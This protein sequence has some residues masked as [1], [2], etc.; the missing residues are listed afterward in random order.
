MTKVTRSL[1][2]TG[3]ESRGAAL[4]LDSQG[5]PTGNAFALKQYIDDLG[6]QN[7]TIVLLGFSYGGIIIREFLNLNPTY[8]EHAKAVVTIDT[9]HNG[10]PGGHPAQHCERGT[11]FIPFRM[12]FGGN[13]VSGRSCPALAKP[14]LSPRES[15]AIARYPK[16][17]WCEIASRRRYSWQSQF[18]CGKPSSSMKAPMDTD[19]IVPV[20]SQLGYGAGRSNYEARTYTSDRWG[21]FDFRQVLHNQILQ[22]DG[23]TEF[24]AFYSS[25][26]QPVIHEIMNPH[27]VLESPAWAGIPEAQAI[28]SATEARVVISQ[29]GTATVGSRVHGCRNRGNYLAGHILGDTIRWH[30]FGLAFGPLFGC[31]QPSIRK[32]GFDQV[33]VRERRG[34]EQHSYTLRAPSVGAWTVQYPAGGYRS[35]RAHLHGAFVQNL[36]TLGMSASTPPRNC[37]LAMRWS[38]ATLLKAAMP[39]MGASATATLTLPDGASVWLTLYDDGTHQDGAAS[40]GVYAN[41]Y[42]AGRRA[43]RTRSR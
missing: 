2:V 20:D 16:I 41:Y 10:K 27:P 38:S 34:A 1:R 5:N 11:W 39:V 17:Q 9:P 12:V 24:D 4:T 33:R 31:H 37:F 25:T 15:G 19:E 42:T 32:W 36:S 30:G 29:S 26:L 21:N 18:P 40:D 14:F 43:A 3:I 28:P 35:G 6:L 7:K 22:D 23:G 8:A 13:H